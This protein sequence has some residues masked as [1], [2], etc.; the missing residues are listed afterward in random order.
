MK[1]P[2][3]KKIHIYPDGLGRVTEIEFMECDTE[4]C[5]YW[6]AVAL[7]YDSFYGT[8]SNWIYKC[9]KVETEC[10]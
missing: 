8:K 7:E 6:G 4:E 5:P 1:C 9:R 10:S 3:R 2:Y